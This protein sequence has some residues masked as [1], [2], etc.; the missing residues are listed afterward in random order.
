MKRLSRFEKVGLMAVLI[1]ACTFF[2]MKRAY[3]PQE[4]VLTK[5]VEK[6]NKVI[7]DINSLKEIPSASALRRTIEKRRQELA[8]VTKELEGTAVRTGAEHE[9]TELLS[10]IN[11][12]LEKNRLA[13]NAVAPKGK[14]AGPLLEWNLYE[15]DMEGRFHAFIWFLN[16][17]LD[18]PDAVK[19]ESIHMEKGANQSLHIAM[20]LMI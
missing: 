10:E 3:V 17:L 18:M 14:V 16:G 8:E 19:I 13:V 4:K 15:V 1:I 2:Y 11:R 5:T 6:L 20:H 12:L 9:I 7:K